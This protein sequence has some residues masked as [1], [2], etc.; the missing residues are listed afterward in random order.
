MIDPIFICQ[1]SSVQKAIQ[2]KE[3]TRGAGQILPLSIPAKAFWVLSGMDALYLPA[4][5]AEKWGCKPGPIHRVQSF[6]TSIADRKSGMPQFILS[7]LFM[8]PS[9]PNTLEF[10]LPVFINALI[11]ASRESGK[12][13]SG[14]D[15]IRTM[16]ILED[17]LTW[18]GEPLDK[19][20]RLFV[21]TLEKAS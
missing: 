20:G 5:M 15:P 7:G 11:A 9:D 14:S 12:N 19:V 16:G 2:F 4:T 17:D 8:D 3:G 1:F 10:A 6:P 21:Q 18:F 13:P